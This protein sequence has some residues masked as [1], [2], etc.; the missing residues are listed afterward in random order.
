MGSRHLET[1]P[2]ASSKLF[3]AIESVEECSQL[4]DA[5]DAAC[6][7]AAM[8]SHKVLGAD[9]NIPTSILVLSEISHTM[10]SL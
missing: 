9:E 8:Y 5:D 1:I 10:S 3:D 4:T 6:A 7:L 2:H